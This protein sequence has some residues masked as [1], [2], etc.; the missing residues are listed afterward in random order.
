MPIKTLWLSGGCENWIQHRLRASQIPTAKAQHA[1][2]AHG[3]PAPEGREVEQ[4]TIEAGQ[5]LE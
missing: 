5:W 2:A 1:E 3:P 4:D